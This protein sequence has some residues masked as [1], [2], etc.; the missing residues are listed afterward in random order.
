MGIKIYVDDERRKPDEFDVVVR[1]NEQL[2]SLLFEL[3]LAE[4]RIETIS[5]D[6]DNMH[7]EDFYAG[8]LWVGARNDWPD[9]LV[10]H[11]ANPVAHERMVKWAQDNAPETTFVDPRFFWPRHLG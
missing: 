6:H 3:S 10:F 1:S 7:G 2:Q 8:L 4:A 5:F 9:N 11:T